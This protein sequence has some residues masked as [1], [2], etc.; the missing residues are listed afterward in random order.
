MK[1]DFGGELIDLQTVQIRYAFEIDA[2]KLAVR[3]LCILDQR[4]KVTYLR[5]IE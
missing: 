4:L 1:S 2:S 5:R 3:K